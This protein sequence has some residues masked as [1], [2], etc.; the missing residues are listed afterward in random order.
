[1]NDWIK[2]IQE[3]KNILSRERF[4][5]MPIA[6][7]EDIQVQLLRCMVRMDATQKRTKIA[8]NFIVAAMHLAFLK[9]S[10]KC[11]LVDLPDNAL[12]LFHG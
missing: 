6:I 5:P 1:M 8:S 9:H 4:T 11:N 12:M 2:L 10:D 7:G 3:F